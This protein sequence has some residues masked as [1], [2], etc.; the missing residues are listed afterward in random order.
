MVRILIFLLWILITQSTWAECLTDLNGVTTCD[1]W[2]GTDTTITSPN[3]KINLA[4]LD[5]VNA[6][7]ANIPSW[8]DAVT[9]LLQKM[10]TFLLFL[11]P[12]IAAVSLVVAGY[13]YIIS[14][15]DTE[16]ASR[17]KTII[18]WNAV[19]IILALTS[20]AIVAV[21]ASILDAKI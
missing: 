14:W 16:K 19:A 13:F 4:E 21:L 15:G 7:S 10:A 9:A 12:L 5:P 3:F 20:Y 17:A 2:G 18:K 11:I 1:N 8:S 6:D